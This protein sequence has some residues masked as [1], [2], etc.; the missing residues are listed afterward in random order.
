MTAILAIPILGEWPAAIDW[1]A[2]ILISVGVYVVSG[3]PL[4][5]R[6]T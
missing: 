6:R 4:A 1:I 5:G 3:G 2:I